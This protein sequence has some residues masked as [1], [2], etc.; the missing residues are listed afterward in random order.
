MIYSMPQI[1]RKSLE[2]LL[3]ASINSGKPRIT[4]QRNS[5]ENVNRYRVNVSINELIVL[6]EDYLFD[7]RH[8][9]F[10]TIGTP[11]N[12]YDSY[13]SFRRKVVEIAELHGFPERAS[14]TSKVNFDRYMTREIT[15]IGDPL[16]IVITNASLE[17]FWNFIHGI[18]LIDVV[19]WRWQ[20]N[21]SPSFN[22]ERINRVSRG[23]LSA[24]WWRYN[25]LTAN[26]LN[27]YADWMDV[28]KQDDIVQIVERPSMRGYH[29]IIIP[30]AKKVA[31]LRNGNLPEGITGDDSLKNLIRAAAI[32]LRI[33]VGSRNI[34][35]MNGRN[36]DFDE[37]VD[38]IFLEA[39]RMIA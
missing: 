22:S 4:L 3:T 17:G 12:D 11:V 8:V 32:R 18:L 30:F 5:K 35:F 14:N 25:V 29:P 34:W 23:A 36:N 6:N 28:L 19:A 9:Y 16:G 24:L 2:N 39:R 33:Y 37:V 20:E 31:S 10:E 21:D 15:R 27:S 1:S 38:S 13:V 26:G 7:E